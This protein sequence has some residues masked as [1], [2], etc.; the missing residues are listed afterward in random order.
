VGDFDGDGCDDLAVGAPGE[1]L[2]EGY[3]AGA[4]SIVYGSPAGL[5]ETVVI[6]QG[7]GGLSG[8]PAGGALVGAALAAGDFNCDGFDDL[9]VGAP[10][11]T[12]RRQRNAGWVGVIGGSASGL[13]TPLATMVQGRPL[14]GVAETGDL[15]GSALAAGDF[16]GDGCDASTRVRSPWCSAVAPVS[17][18]PAPSTRTRTFPGAVAPATS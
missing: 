8:R 6:Y 3:A 9:A 11:Q 4:V 17:A 14:P 5:A 12:V 16:D 1:G 2:D 18:P 7:S 15:T 13:R 10:G